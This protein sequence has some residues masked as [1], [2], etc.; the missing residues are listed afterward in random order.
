MITIELIVMLVA[1]VLIGVLIG[2][3]LFLFGR[4]PTLPSVSLP[5]RGS[6]HSEDELSDDLFRIFQRGVGYPLFIEV[7]DRRYR[8]VADIEGERERALIL[9][10]LRKL[11]TQVSAEELKAAEVD[12]EPVDEEPIAVQPAATP[13]VAA[14]DAVPATAATQQSTTNRFLVDEIDELFQSILDTMPEVPDASLTTAPDGSMRI[15]FDGD[16]YDDVDAVPNVDVQDALRTA[17]KRWE[18]RV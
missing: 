1:S 5:G 7:G 4:Q 8:S 16:V 11:L 10:A 6:S 9:T 17:V 14:A 15:Q 13:A 2:F 3:L 12:E 18:K